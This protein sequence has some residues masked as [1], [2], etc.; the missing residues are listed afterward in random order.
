M[1][2]SFDDFQSRFRMHPTLGE[3]VEIDNLDVEAAHD[4]QSWGR[5]EMQRAGGKVR[6]AA[7]A[8]DRL[9]TG[10]VTDARRNRSRGAGACS[11][12]PYRQRSNVGLRLEPIGRT[13]DTVG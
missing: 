12:I 3:L 6:P 4:Q 10:L 13:I 1:G 5:G 2:C 11:E 9:D 8:D 7:P